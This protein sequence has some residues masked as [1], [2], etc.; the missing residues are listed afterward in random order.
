MRHALAPTL[1]NLC[2]R[3]YKNS[4]QQRLNVNCREQTTLSFNFLIVAR[5]WCSSVNLIVKTLTIYNCLWMCCLPY[6]KAN[7]AHWQTPSNHF[8]RLFNRQTY[9][10]RFFHLKFIATK[11]THWKF[12]K[13]KKIKKKREFYLKNM[14]YL[15]GTNSWVRRWRKKRRAVSLGRSQV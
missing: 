7:Q 6:A 15:K 5:W 3:Y 13:V 14:Q 1:I 8:M 9:A 2:H 10:F 4:S 11:N 12:N